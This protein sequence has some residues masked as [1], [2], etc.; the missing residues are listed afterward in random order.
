MVQTVP[1]KKK[2]PDFNCQLLSQVTIYHR[3]CI[4][5]FPSVAKEINNTVHDVACAREESWYYDSHELKIVR[6]INNKR[7][8]MFK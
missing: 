5:G 7:I 1:Y 8:S 2:R 6:K 4:Y 3:L